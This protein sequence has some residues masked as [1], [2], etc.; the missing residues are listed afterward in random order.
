VTITGIANGYDGKVLHLINRSAANTMTLA[1]D[2][3]SSLAAN[4]IFT[5]TGANLNVA[6][7]AMVSLQYDYNFNGSGAHW[8]V[9]GAPSSVTQGATVAGSSGQVQFNNSGA[10]GATGKL[11]WNNTDA[12]LIVSNAGA[13]TT[14]PQWLSH[15]PKIS[16]IA[17]S[18]SFL[19]PVIG[20]D[21]FSDATGVRNDY[22]PSLMLARSN[23]G[24]EG[25]FTNPVNNQTLGSIE[26]SGAVT[27]P[28]G[29]FTPSASIL[30]ATSENWSNTA[31]GTYL[32]F[33]TT[34]NTTSALT[35]RMRIN[36]DG[37][38][39]ITNLAS[40]AG[41]QTNASG[42]MS[43]TSDATLK[44]IHGDFT[45]GLD[46]VMNIHPK[47]YSWKEGTNLY[48]G[49]VLYHGFIAQDVQQALPEAVNTGASGKLQVG[50][51]PIL[52]ASVNAI[53]EQQAE[54]DLL[55]AEL[56]KHDSTYAWCN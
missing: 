3:G 33:W 9:V 40:C 13:V 15:K 10:F 42:L 55:K 45:P 28:F 26:F 12:D 20:V 37:T 25:T 5:G 23:S 54:I 47:T 39:Q 30:A 48:D 14:A 24:S 16:V 27:S 49:G 1:N 36:Q 38:V 51:T 41:V 19:F 17:G 22:W 56:C 50:T 29:R 44:D 35:E 18:A 46:A 7:G 34:A 6:A 2:S 4:R 11:H 53:K 8:R 21:S 43:C 52:A 32:G 31:N